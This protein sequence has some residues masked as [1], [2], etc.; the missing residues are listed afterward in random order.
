MKKIPAWMKVVFVLIV[1]GNVA[2]MAVTQDLHLATPFLLGLSTGFI[3][4]VIIGRR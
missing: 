4:G 1:G 3:G 2:I